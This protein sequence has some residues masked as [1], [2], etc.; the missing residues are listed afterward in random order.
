MTCPNEEICT[1]TLNTQP[2]CDKKVSKPN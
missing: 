1:L 2:V